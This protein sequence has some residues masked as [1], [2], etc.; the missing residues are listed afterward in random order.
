[1]N[2]IMKNLRRFA[3]PLER[4]VSAILVKVRRGADVDAV[5]GE[6]GKVPEISALRG[7]E[8]RWSR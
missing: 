8:F 4:C 1:M 6:I 3:P 5:A 2:I 7:E